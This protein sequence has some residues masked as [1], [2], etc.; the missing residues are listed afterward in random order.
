MS[1]VVDINVA[2]QRLV[3]EQ[4]A[5]D[6]RAQCAAARQVRSDIDGLLDSLSG[7]I[8]ASLAE[9][10]LVNRDQAVR[11]VGEPARPRCVHKPWPG[12]SG[13]WPRISAWMFFPTDP[14]LT[15]S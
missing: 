6:F 4:S 14:T 1:N 8:P 5:T 7:V 10:E 2:Y 15:S 9:D 11:V 13:Y 3:L 12:R